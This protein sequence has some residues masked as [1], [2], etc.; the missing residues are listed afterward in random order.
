MMAVHG[1]IANPCPICNPGKILRVER[2]EMIWNWNKKKECVKEHPFLAKIKK[3]DS[4][5]IFGE[6]RWELI[7]N[8]TLKLYAKNNRRDGFGGIDYSKP[9]YIEIPLNHIPGVD[10][11]EFRWNYDDT[12]K[13]GYA[14]IYALD[15]ESS[16]GGETKYDSVQVEI[17]I[18]AM[19]YHME[20]EKNKREQEEQMKEDRLSGKNDASVKD[21][22]KYLYER[23]VRHLGV[24]K[25]EPSEECLKNLK[26]EDKVECTIC[27]VIELLREGG[28][29]S[30]EELVKNIKF[31]ELLRENGFTV[32]EELV[33]NI[34]KHGMGLVAYGK[35]LEKEKKE[36]ETLTE[37]QKNRIKDFFSSCG[38]NWDINIINHIDSPFADYIRELYKESEKKKKEDEVIKAITS[39]FS[40]ESSEIDRI[41]VE[42]RGNRSGICKEITRTKN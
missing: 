19:I 42:L 21:L 36:E 1:C 35:K 5:D 39:L 26:E 37:D 28:C 22:E 16:W 14:S 3:W 18:R 34:Y 32:S 7:K 2:A 25:L 38:T 41:C 17:P 29:T 15:P 30:S 40:I 20:R 31:I 12:G 6:E 4:K 10:G 9:E 27:E 8:G 33:K 24:A 11:C 23:A 13:Y